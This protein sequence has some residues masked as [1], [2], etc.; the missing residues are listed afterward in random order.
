MKKVKDVIYGVSV[1][2][3]ALLAV[4]YFIA[5]AMD[6]L[7]DIGNY[8]LEGG[9]LFVTMLAMSGTLIRYPIKQVVKNTINMLKRDIK[10]WQK[11]RQKKH[12][13]KKATNK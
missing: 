8:S 2:Y 13:S 1:G 12:D 6:G 9:W 5:I 3:L 7:A 4:F 10:A 11:D